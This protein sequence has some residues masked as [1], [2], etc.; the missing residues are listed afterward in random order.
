V[1][2]EEEIVNWQDHTSADDQAEEPATP[3]PV[4]INH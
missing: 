2:T 4:V 1:V 3:H